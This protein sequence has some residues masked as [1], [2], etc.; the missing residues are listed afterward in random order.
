M[1]VIAVVG[2]VVL[3]LLALVRID[4]PAGLAAGGVLGAGGAFSGVLAL[5]RRVRGIPDPLSGIDTH[6]DPEQA[7]TIGLAMT[8]PRMRSF[9]LL[10]VGVAIVYGVV[11]A[12]D[13]GRRSALAVAAVIMVGIAALFG[14]VGVLT[15]RA[16]HRRTTALADA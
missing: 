14:V 4:S 7:K 12:A 2:G 10:F 16:H 5:S 3:F 1:H 6:Q 11:A 15:W 9:A 8:W 13:P